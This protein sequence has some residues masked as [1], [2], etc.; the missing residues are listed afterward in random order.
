MMWRSPVSL[1]ASGQALSCCGGGVQPR[2]WRFRWRQ[3]AATVRRMCAPTRSVRRKRRRHWS[4]GSSPLSRR[5]VLCGRSRSVF[6]GGGPERGEPRRVRRRFVC[7]FGLRVLS[8]AKLRR[9]SAAHAGT[10]GRRQ[11][12]GGRDAICARLRAAIAQATGGAHPVGEDCGQRNLTR[13]SHLSPNM[14]Q[15]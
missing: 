13:C 7:R 6:G 9:P 5:R 2:C 15:S 14:D 1:L 8:P 4:T 3:L 10:V 12:V 11:S